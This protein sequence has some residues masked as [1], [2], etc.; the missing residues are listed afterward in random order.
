M[1]FVVACGGARSPVEDPAR[2]REAMVRD[3]VEARGVTDARTLAALRKVERHLFVPPAQAA[4]AY[5]DIRCDRRGPDHLAALH[6]RG[7]DGGDRSPRRRARARDRTGSGYQAAVLAEMGAKV[8]TVEIVRAWPGTRARRWH[9][10]ATAD[11]GTGGERLGG[12]GGQGPFDAIVVT[13]AP[14]AYRGVEEPAARR[15]TPRDS[16]R[17]RRA[18]AAAADAARLFLRGAAAPARALRAARGRAPLT[19]GPGSPSENG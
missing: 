18:G 16:G 14:K 9:G 7:D 12:L 15:R 3:Q 10:S 19:V 11:R 8:Y 6:R 2:A 1:L 17:R 5:A 13:A 4:L